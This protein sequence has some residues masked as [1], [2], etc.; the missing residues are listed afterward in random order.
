MGAVSFYC[1]NTGNEPCFLKS[2]VCTLDSADIGEQHLRNMGTTDLT[3]KG[4]ALKSPVKIRPK[5][6]CVPAQNPSFV[7]KVYQR[8]RLNAEKTLLAD[9]R[10]KLRVM[11]RHYYHTLSCENLTKANEQANLSISSKADRQGAPCNQIY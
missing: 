8:L 1:T 3:A 11:V 7:K 5:Y 10:E 6:F 2:L 9:Y 4:A